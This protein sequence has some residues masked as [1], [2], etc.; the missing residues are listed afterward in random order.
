MGCKNDVYILHEEDR[1]KHSVWN[2]GWSGRCKNYFLAWGFLVGGERANFY[3]EDS[4]SFGFM[5]R[6]LRRKV[7]KTR[8]GTIIN[9]NHI[10][11]VVLWTAV[12]IY[13]DHREAP[14]G[15][16][17][18]F[19]PPKWQR[20]GKLDRYIVTILMSKTA[21]SPDPL[22]SAVWFVRGY[23]VFRYSEG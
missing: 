18:M 23:N 17:I 22:R 6:L 3:R 8:I 10:P 5:S 13:F 12:G 21:W 11:T 9:I 19:P 1:E 15:Y 16:P 4:L 7:S 14:Q 20:A 2:Y